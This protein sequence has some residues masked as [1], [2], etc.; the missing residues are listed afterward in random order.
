M[1]VNMW[2]IAGEVA[3]ALAE[4]RGVVALESALVT[5]GLPWPDNVEV[6]REAEE[7]VRRSGAVPATIAIMEGRIRV[8]LSAEEL[9]RLAR[10]GPFHKAGRRDLG[11]AVA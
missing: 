4:G 11:G 6:A 8:G 3:E 1:S 5:H 10:P 7:A 2:G 9:E